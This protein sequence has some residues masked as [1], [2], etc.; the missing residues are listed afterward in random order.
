MRLRARLERIERTRGRADDRREDI[1]ALVKH[2]TPEE[3][4]RVRMILSRWPP[5][6]AQAPSDLKELLEL[7]HT[8]LARKAQL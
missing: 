8:A 7:A 6:A 4:A 5:G 3:R 1:A 2:M